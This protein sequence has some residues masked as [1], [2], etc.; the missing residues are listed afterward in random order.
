VSLNI[1]QQA[2]RDHEKIQGFHYESY[3]PCNL[4]YDFQRD[5]LLAQ[6]DTEP[7]ISL[8]A[9]KSNSRCPDP[10]LDLVNYYLGKNDAKDAKTYLDNLIKQAPKRGDLIIDE[11]RVNTLLKNPVALKN[12]AQQGLNLGYLKVTSSPTKKANGVVGQVKNATGPT[13]NQKSVT[14][15]KQ[16]SSQ[17]KPVN[18]GKK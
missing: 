1:T 17:Q 10:Q 8:T 12:F 16:Q 3:M 2:L 4:Y 15:S 11:L 7:S 9:L 14:E 6:G 5:I 18:T 13:I